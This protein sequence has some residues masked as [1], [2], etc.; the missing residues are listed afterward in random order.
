MS[1]VC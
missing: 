1:T